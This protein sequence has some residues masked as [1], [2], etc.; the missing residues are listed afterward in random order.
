MLDLR[1]LMLDHM[2]PTW[3]LITLWTVLVRIAF[4]SLAAMGGM[5]GDSITAARGTCLDWLQHCLLL[6]DLK[7]D[8]LQ[9]MLDLRLRLR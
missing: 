3:L 7:L 1:L 9:L 5:P 6:L 2:L 8:W 4:A